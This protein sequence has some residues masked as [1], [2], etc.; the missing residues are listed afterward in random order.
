MLGKTGKQQC[1]NPGVPRLDRGNWGGECDSFFYRVLARSSWRML[2]FVKD[3][4]FYVHLTYKDDD[5]F[6]NGSVHEW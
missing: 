1:K 5:L 2:R 6:R 4:P 3:Y